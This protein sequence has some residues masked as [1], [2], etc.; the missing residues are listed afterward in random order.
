MFVIICQDRDDV[1]LDI[2]G[3]DGIPEVGLA[4]VRVRVRVAV[5]RVRIRV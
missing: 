3:V 2:H 5:V 1:T 4:R